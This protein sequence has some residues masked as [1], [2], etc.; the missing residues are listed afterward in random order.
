MTEENNIEEKTREGPPKKTLPL[1]VGA[2][3]GVA[4]IC[5]AILAILPAP[6]GPV[7]KDPLRSLLTGL[8]VVGLACPLCIAGIALKKRSAA[9]PYYE[10]AFIA[11]TL[12]LFGFLCLSV[13]L[14]CIAFGIYDLVIRFLAP[15]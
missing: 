8:G 7:L 3:I 9:S 10:G 11:T 6:E 1:A 13:G 4:V 2:S 15:G 5:F 14:V 12:S